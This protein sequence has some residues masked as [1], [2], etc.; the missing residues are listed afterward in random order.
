[1]LAGSLEQQGDDHDD[2]KRR[3]QK[4]GN[5]CR[6]RIILSDQG[7][8]VGASTP[9][10]K[11][12]KTQSFVAVSSTGGS[13]GKGGNPRPAR[14]EF[15][16][17]GLS[18]AEVAPVQPL[19]GGLQVARRHRFKGEGADKDE[20][21]HE[22]A[23]RGVLTMDQQGCAAVEPFG[24]V[25]PDP[26]SP[27]PAAHLVYHKPPLI[28][29]QRDVEGAPFPVQAQLEM[30]RVCAFGGDLKEELL[31]V[32]SAFRR[33]RLVQGGANAQR[34]HRLAAGSGERG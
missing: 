34:V 8:C 9:R 1:M 12:V 24:Q 26:L 30:A 21:D 29:A 27:F 22:Q 31:A 20:T 17:C 16:P 32:H 7:E 11:D 33:L 28:K 3:S 15:H 13:G 18:G 19:A 14:A 5:N 2:K 23:D 10:R 25:M 4:P 6:H